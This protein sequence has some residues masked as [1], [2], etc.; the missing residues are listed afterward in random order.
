[1]K[2]IFSKYYFS[3][4]L[5]CRE[6]PSSKYFPY[7]SSSLSL[8]F[9]PHDYFFLPQIFPIKPLSSSEYPSYKWF[10]FLQN[11]FFLVYFFPYKVIVFRKLFSTRTS[12]LIPY[13]YFFL[14]YI[15]LF[16]Y[17]IFSR[18]SSPPEYLYP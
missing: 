12:V 18:T 7:K 2:F 10:F 9:F 17:E 3:V 11:I 5:T 16:M 8:L 15:S 4:F 13:E 6:F 14:Q 1:M